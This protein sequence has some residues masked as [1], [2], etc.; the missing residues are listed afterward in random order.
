VAYYAYE[1]DSPPTLYVSA[2]DASKPR[3]LLETSHE[4]WLSPVDWSPDGREVAILEWPGHEVV[5]SVAKT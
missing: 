5:L 1:I 3:K 2:I 4:S